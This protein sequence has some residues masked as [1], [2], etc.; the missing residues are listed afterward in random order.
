M[1]D[2]KLGVVASDEQ[3]TVQIQDG[4]QCLTLDYDGARRFH[5]GD[6]WW[7]V[8]VGFRA[9]QMAGELLSVETLWCRTGLSVVSGH[10]GPGVRDGIDYVTGAVQA[11]RYQLTPDQQ[12]RTACGRD[13]KFQW[14]VS[15]GSMTAI[16][17]L[18]DDFVPEQFYEQLDLML[19]GEKTDENRRMFDALKLELETKIWQTPL[20]SAFCAKLAPVPLDEALALSAV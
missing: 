15:D 5:E 19:Q 2:L 1:T 12:G 14:W 18:R 10:P 6:S 8:A 16:V 13:M 17:F 4:D 3:A 11:D 20:S 9:M 7:G